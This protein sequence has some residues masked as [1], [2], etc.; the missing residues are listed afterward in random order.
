MTTELVMDLIKNAIYMIILVSAPVLIVS[1]VI[2]L[3]IS[4]LQTTTS[5]QEQTLSFV[6]K[7]L[8]VLGS[9]IY[10]GYFIVEKLT[11]YTMSIFKMLPTMGL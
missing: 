10:F 5:I 6:P 8:A 2:G 11:D 7:I 4:I 9:L 1:V 3:V